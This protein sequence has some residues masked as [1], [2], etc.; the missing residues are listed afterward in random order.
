MLTALA[1]MNHALTALGHAGLQLTL[2]DDD[3]VS[4][5]NIGRQLF[6]SSEIGLAKSVA[7]I[8]RVNRFFGTSWKAEERKFPGE[9][10]SEDA[11]RSE[12]RR[13]GKECV[14]TCRSRWSPYH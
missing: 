2:W 4:S 9:A 3:R 5:A 12:E 13:V 1:K 10:I 14:S 6:A 7:L 8:N 11:F